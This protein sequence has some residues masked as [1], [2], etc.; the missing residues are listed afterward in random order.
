MP[1][2][3]ANYNPHRAG[4]IIAN[5]KPRV[6]PYPATPTYTAHVNG[7]R[8]QPT[9]RGNFFLRQNAPAQPAGAVAMDS[10]DAGHG[11]GSPTSTPVASGCGCG[12]K[13]GGKS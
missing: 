8:L 4:G 12:G 2:L 11:G 10:P 13:C 6:Y 9:E 7:Q 5:S 1:P 3:F